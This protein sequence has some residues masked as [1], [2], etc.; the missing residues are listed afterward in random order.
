MIHGNTTWDITYLTAELEAQD[1]GI[2]PM[3]MF[4]IW[5]GR[6]N[7]LFNYGLRK[8]DI[9]I[10]R[11]D[12]LFGEVCEFVYPTE[13]IRFTGTLIDALEFIQKRLPVTCYFKDGEA[14]K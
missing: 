11:S 5:N 9:D 4:R 6:L 14:T 12:P 13:E 1:K 2:E 8:S 3:A 10:S 7:Y